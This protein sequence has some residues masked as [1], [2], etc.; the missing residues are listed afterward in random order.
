MCGP[1]SCGPLEL[2]RTENELRRSELLLGL[3]RTENEL[4]RS[5]LLLGL[6]RYCVPG[7]AWRR[8]PPP[9]ASHR[10]QC[11][12]SPILAARMDDND[13]EELREREREQ[14][15]L[16]SRLMARIAELEEKVYLHEFNEEQPRRGAHAPPCLSRRCRAAARAGVYLSLRGKS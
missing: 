3:Q 5:E 9:V 4:R 2:L 10:H 6:Q 7:H 12:T 14:E 15:V 16:I 1:L 8:I 13:V 11:G